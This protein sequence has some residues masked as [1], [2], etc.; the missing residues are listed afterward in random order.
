MQLTVIVPVYNVSAW[1][2]ACLDSLAAQTLPGLEVLL[3]DDGSTDG[4][5]AVCAA[6]CAADSRF[7]LL[8]Q[9]HSGVS[10]ARNLGLRHASGELI[11]FAD[12]DDWLEPDMYRLLAEALEQGQA[13][14]AMCGYYEHLPQEGVPPLARGADKAAV[15]D[16]DAALLEV[17]R[18][19]GSY[20]AVWNKLFRRQAICPGGAWI[21]FDSAYAYGEDEQ[22]LVRVLLGIRRAAVLPAPLYHW[23]S[24]S[25]SA[26]RSDLVTPAM[27]TVLP[28]KTD[29]IRL[30]RDRA[31]LCRLSAARLVNDCFLLW[32][33]AWLAKQ[34]DALRQVRQALAP[35]WGDFVR[36]A[37]VP[38]AR[39]LKVLLLR[40][41]MALHAPR[42]L[43][44]FLRDAG[45]AQRG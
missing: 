17:L 36:C 16:A 34:N 43:V 7:R 22:W 28:A 8:R 18:R 1:L 14:C 35:C 5:D 31:A 30:L 29:T 33:N 3:V 24:R 10:A 11:A 26:S 39:R 40:L 42:S 9:P 20:C 19:G 15:L 21:D 27:L 12:S 4:S 41:L 37:D 44:R 38:A 23:R 32:V 45:R 6:R 2:P 13:D 25:G